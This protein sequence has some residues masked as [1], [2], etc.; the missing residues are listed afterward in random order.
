MGSFLLSELNEALNNPEGSE[1][2]K[3]GSTGEGGIV[4][5][6]PKTGEIYDPKNPPAEPQGKPGTLKDPDQPQPVP[7]VPTGARGLCDFIFKKC[8]G[9]CPTLK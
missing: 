6:D 8:L 7:D 2:Q 5:R 3:P 9:A 4:G 1:N